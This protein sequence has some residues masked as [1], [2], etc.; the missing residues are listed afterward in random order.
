MNAPRRICVVTGARADYGLLSSLMREIRGDETLEL[1]T[2]ATGAHLLPE[3]GLTVREIEADGF[4]VDARVDIGLAADDPLEAAR[5]TG[6][7]VVGIAEALSRLAP[8]AVVLLGDRYEILAAAVAAFVLG[9]PI[10]HIH[11]GEITEGAMDDSIRHAVTKLAHLHFAAAE[12]YATRILQM[13]ETPN[14]VFN[15]GAL[16][17]DAALALRP[18]SRAEMDRDLGLPLRDPVLLVTYHPVTLRDSDE[19]A[20]V[21]AMVAALD[22]VAEARVV[23]TGVNADPG[24][25]VVARRLAD[26]AARHPRR[27]SLHESLGQRRYLSVMREAAAVVGN[28]SSGVI[29]AP[30]LGVPTV[31]IGARQ[32]GR[33]KA[34]S[35]IDC[36]ETANEIAG[37][38]ARVMEPAFR[39]RIADQHLPYGGGGTARKIAA[40]LKSVD[41]GRLKYKIFRDLPEA[42]A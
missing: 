29:E 27:V 39:R 30:A 40:V 36:G 21:D 12:P 6:R 11:G 35:V 24:R 37:A 26:Y 13:G 3:F 28:S 16:G 2:I 5:A 23:I 25:T 20:A 18:L 8:N 34:P 41:L 9:L 17:V 42:A 32:K 1:V 33:L 10:A 7:G 14:R 31:N 19:R 38:I 4:S 15:V 22:T